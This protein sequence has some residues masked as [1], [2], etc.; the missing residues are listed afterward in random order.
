MDWST[1]TP[2]EHARAL[3]DWST[4]GYR[5]TTVVTN[6]SANGRTAS[7]MLAQ[8]PLLPSTSAASTASPVQEVSE[9]KALMSTLRSELLTERTRR[10][11]AERHAVELTR[12]L[13]S[14]TSKVVAEA[15]LAE[16]YRR[17]FEELQLMF[18]D[19]KRK[20]QNMHSEYTEI[21]SRC[22]D[23][24]NAL[25]EKDE[26]IAHLEEDA[27]K[28]NEEII[29]LRSGLEEIRCR[30][31]A[32]RE[33]KKQMQVHGGTGGSLSSTREGRISLDSSQL[34]VDSSHSQTMSQPTTPQRTSWTVASLA[35]TP[36]RQ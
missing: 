32:A 1:L 35:S 13:Q 30:E 7:P 16:E 5:A 14:A 28:L 9:V 15:Q 12:Q 20:Y 23:Q 10:E 22:F 6:G 21:E 24:Q 27:T 31:R 25:H 29:Q 34:S 26:L 8:R 4:N 33:K 36:S 3:K 18:E 19:G 17:K 2:S 11:A